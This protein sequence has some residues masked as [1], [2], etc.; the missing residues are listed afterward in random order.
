M[1]ISQDFEE[2]F[3]LLNEN[4]VRYL[5]VGGYAYAIH[6]EPRYTKDLDIF[7]ESETENAAILLN[8]LEK[9]GFGE[10]DITVNDLT[11]SVR[12]IQLGVP[13]LRIDLINEIEGVSFSDAWEDKIKAEYGNQEMH[14]I[15]KL[16]LI[17]NKKAVGRDQDLLDVKKIRR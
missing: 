6:A 1:E 15:S 7:F 3:K 16:N 17:R 9:F 14:V 2:F 8:C 5:V 11:K 12:I 13:P 10:L 4:N